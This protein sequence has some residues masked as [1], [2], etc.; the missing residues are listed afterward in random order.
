MPK[1]R[2][3]GRWWVGAAVELVAV[4]AVASG[5]STLTPRLAA[6]V[7]AIAVVWSVGII[8]QLLKGWNEHT[9]VVAL[10]P[11]ATLAQVASASRE[12]G[13]RDIDADPVQRA[14]PVK[15]GETTSHADLMSA[16]GLG[17]LIQATVGSFG[18]VGRRCLNR[19]G[20]AA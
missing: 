1:P 12:L 3:G 9:A 4:A 14:E 7:I 2:R 13:A 10:E 20:L 6:P 17:S 11:A 5:V 18:G 16:S 19:A 15:A 8:C